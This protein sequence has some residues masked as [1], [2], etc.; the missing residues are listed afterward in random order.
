MTKRCTGRCRSAFLPHGEAVRCP[1]YAGGRGEKGPRPVRSGR[2]GAAAPGQ[3]D[4]PAGAGRSAGLSLRHAKDRSGSPRPADVVPHRSVYGAGP[5]R[6]PQSG[7][8]G[9]AAGQGKAGQPAVGA[10]QDQDRHGRPQPAGVARA[11]A[12]GRGRHRPAAQRRGGTGGAHRGPG[13]ADAGP[14]RHRRY[15]AA[16]RPGGLRLCRRT[17]S[18]IP[19]RLHGAAA[20]RQ[21]AAGRLP[22]RCAAPVG[23]AAGGSQ[24]SGRPHWRDVGGRAAVL[25]P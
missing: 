18:G 15:G 1:L 22:L 17:G 20:R 2:A 16:H 3:Y 25:R 4:A 19:A 21:G 13:G 12:G 5:H 14:Q 10:G 9:D 6:P 23:S 7:A 8:D 24:R 11:A